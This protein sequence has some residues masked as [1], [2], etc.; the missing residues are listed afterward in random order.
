M[1]NAFQITANP[2]TPPPNLPVIT[3]VLPKR[4]LL[5][6]ATVFNVTG[7]NFLAHATNG[8]AFTVTNVT[9]GGRDCVFKVY[10][11]SN[12]KVTVPPWSKFESTNDLA[13]ATN[14]LDIVVATGAGVGTLTNAVSFDLTLPNDANH[15]IPLT[16][17]ELKAQKM[18]DAV[19]YSA[20]VM[21]TNL[22]VEPEVKI[23]TSSGPPH[24]LPWDKRDA[25]IPSISAGFHIGTPNEP[26]HGPAQ[27]AGG[28]N[29]PG[30]S[31]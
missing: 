25:A 13:L 21:G 28:T 31:P 8:M 3:Q 24:D 29:S 11:D 19:I 9:V 15:S 23:T 10:S 18:L 16:A 12:L 7:S 30:Q 1:S 22:V 20:R 5:F 6:S 14:K 17:D 2:I 26:G 27:P 4:G